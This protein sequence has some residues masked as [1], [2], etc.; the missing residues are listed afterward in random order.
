[1]KKK[2]SGPGG[3]ENAELYTAQGMAFF[4]RDG[5][6]FPVAADFA[7]EYRGLFVV[8]KKAG[9]Y[10]VTLQR[11]CCVFAVKIFGVP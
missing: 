4:G 7:N 2:K 5:R 8:G 6:F 10:H 9:P 3:L 11:K 1:M